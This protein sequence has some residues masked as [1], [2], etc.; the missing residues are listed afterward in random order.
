MTVIDYLNQV[1]IQNAC[2]YLRSSDKEVGDIALLCGFR[3]AAYFSN[4]FKRLTG[5]SPSA[6]RKA[7][8]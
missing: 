1:R 4:V 8:T 7:S 3:D 6:Y 2:R 5:T